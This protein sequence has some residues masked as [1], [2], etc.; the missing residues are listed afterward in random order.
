MKSLTEKRVRDAKPKKAAYLLRDSTMPGLALR[1]YPGGS[2]SYVLE[3]R[4]G[5]RRAVGTLANA[6]HVSLAEA[7]DMARQEMVGNARGDTDILTRKADAR[8]A[9]TVA[10]LCDWFLNDHCPDR[11]AQGRMKDRTRFDYEKQIRG[12][13]LP[14][15]GK[16]AVRDVT[17]DQIER[18][19]RD[20]GRVQRNRLI[21]LLHRIFTLAERKGWRVQG[22]NPVK[23][24][25]KGKET[26]RDRTLSDAE[27]G[28]LSAALTELQDVHPSAVGAIRFAAMSGLRIGEVLAIDVEHLD[29]DSGRLLLPDSKSGRRWHDVGPAALSVVHDTASVPDS[30]FLFGSPKSGGQTHY[31]TVYDVFAKACE[32]A[33]VEDARLHDLRRGFA[34]RAAASGINT[35]VLRDLLGHRSTAMAD[36]YIRH[37]GRSVAEARATTGDAIANAMTR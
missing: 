16:L 22:H 2:K 36:R 6:A 4:Q 27:L 33:K 8:K 26:P 34:T 10:E 35:H 14:R 37:V 23:G 24:V 17:T 9:E 5:N 21:A 31:R 15:L 18:A 7:R 20:R 30:Q 11:I 32:M 13:V 12:T 1:V 29:L 19:V 28:R 3:Y 25:E